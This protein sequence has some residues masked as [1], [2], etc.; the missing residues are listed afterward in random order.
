MCPI[1][2]RLET[3]EPPWLSLWTTTCKQYLGPKCQILILDIVNECE[4][5]KSQVPTIGRFQCI[6]HISIESIGILDVLRKNIEKMELQCD[7]LHVSGSNSSAPCSASM[8][9]WKPL[10][11]TS[12]WL[13]RWDAWL[14]WD[15]VPL[16]W[17]FR[18]FVWQEWYYRFQEL[19]NWFFLSKSSVQVIRM[20]A[21]ITG[22]GVLVSFV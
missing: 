18:P 19:A 16:F 17:L 12:Q 5:K 3:L 6:T 8:P 4:C 20:N 14:S 9:P 11:K 15:V 2:R 1:W 13:R 7:F 22:K 21:V 10:M